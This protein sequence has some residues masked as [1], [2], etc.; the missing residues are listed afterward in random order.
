MKP[1]LRWILDSVLPPS[2]LVCSEPVQADGQF[3]AVCFG[4]V[5]FI[6]SPFCACCGVPFNFQPA[7]GAEHLCMAC[8]ESHPAY[9]M[10]RA[11]ILYDESARR[12]I[13]PFKYGDRAESAPNLARLMVR[14]GGSLL[15]SA[16]L[17]VPVPLHVSRL[18]Q[19]RYNQA[20]LLAKALAKQTG[21]PVELDA[22]VRTRE[23]RKLEGMDVPTRRQEL[24]NAITFKPQK[25]MKGK[26]VLLIDDVMTTGATAHQCARALRAAGAGQVDVLTIARVADPRFMQN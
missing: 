10:A 7:F 13:L 21:K 6:T 26:R 12:M 3:C 22:L 8:N 14:A 24:D 11:A 1:L 18:R 15:Q 16:D 23:T 17:L 5:N 19:R 25:H 4:K 20:A 9:T 2:C